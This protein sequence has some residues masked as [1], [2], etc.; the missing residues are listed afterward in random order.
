MIVQTTGYI[1]VIR[2]R[3]HDSGVSQKARKLLATFESTESGETLILNDQAAN[4]SY[5]IDYA[6]IEEFAAQ[7]R[8]AEKEKVWN[9]R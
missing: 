3:V 2:Q 7:A 6:K 4:V 1:T 9:I 5:C 8:N